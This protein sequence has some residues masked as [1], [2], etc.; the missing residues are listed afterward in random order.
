MNASLIHEAARATHE[1]QLPFPEIVGLLI[2]AGVEF[3]HVDYLART[4]TY[5]DGAGEQ[6]VVELPYENLPPVAADFDAE[7]VRA[8]I[9][10]SQLHGQT[11][12]AFSRRVMAAG[13]QGYH[14][15][16]RG[17]RVIYTGRQGDQHIEWFP[18]AR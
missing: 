4:T 15:F 17:Q 18:G 5:H 8:A 3:Y 2:Q 10:D 9:L 13:T 7:A 11:H 12:E 6:L 16:L 1:A 14:A